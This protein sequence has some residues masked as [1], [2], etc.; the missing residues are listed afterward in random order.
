MTPERSRAHSYDGFNVNRWLYECRL[1]A[2]AK[3]TM[4]SETHT[5]RSI[6]PFA[7]VPSPPPPLP[8]PLSSTY[9]KLGDEIEGESFCH[10]CHNKIYSCLSQLAAACLCV[11]IHTHAHTHTNLGWCTQKRC[12]TVWM[13]HTW[14]GCSGPILGEFSTRGQMRDWCRCTLASNNSP[15]VSL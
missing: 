8:P 15:T 11:R 13:H 4:Q 5:I 2:Q 9:C 10:W 1:R 7:I 6:S 12:R 14:R 3:E